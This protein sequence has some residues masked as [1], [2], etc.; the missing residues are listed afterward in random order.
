MEMAMAAIPKVENNKASVPWLAGGF[1]PL[2]EARVS[3]E[4]VSFELAGQLP[5]IMDG[6]SNGQ[7]TPSGR[8][9]HDRATEVCVPAKFRMVTVDMLK[10]P[11]FRFNT[12]GEA[13]RLRLA[14]V[15]EQ[16]G[17]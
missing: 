17:E 14:E 5:E 2:P 12:A 16:C 9:E 3:A 6:G 10:V 13:S 4:T 11:F 15:A 7:T 1:S 8:F